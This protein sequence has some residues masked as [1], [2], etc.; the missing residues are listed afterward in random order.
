MERNSLNDPPAVENHPAGNR[1]VTKDTG[2]SARA[3]GRRG[4]PKADTA[5]VYADRPYERN[6]TQRGRR[7]ISID[8]DSALLARIDAQRGAVR[9]GVFLD[10][11]LSRAIDSQEGQQTMT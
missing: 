8:I 10:S 11:L 4:V 6:L 1:K 7:F 9:R 2:R 5:G 3:E